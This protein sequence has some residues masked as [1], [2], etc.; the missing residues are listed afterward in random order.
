MWQDFL[1]GPVTKTLPSQCRGPG[2]NSWSGN[3][4]SHA[5]TKDSMCHNRDSVQ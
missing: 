2:F 3:W 5:A 1:G 4:I